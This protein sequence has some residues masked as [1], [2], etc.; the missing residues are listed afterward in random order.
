MKAILSFLLLVSCCLLLHNSNASFTP[1]TAIVDFIDYN[2]PPSFYTCISK[3]FNYNQDS[4]VIVTYNPQ[5]AIEETVISLRNSGYNFVH[6]LL[7]FNV[8]GRLIYSDELR[9]IATSLYT[10][11]TSVQGIW[12]AVTANPY[13]VPLAT[14]PMYNQFMINN[15]FYGVSS[16]FGGMGNVTMGIKTNHVD[17]NNIIGYDVDAFNQYPLWTDITENNS[18]VAMWESAVLKQILANSSACVYPANVD[19]VLTSFSIS[20]Q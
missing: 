1:N 10:V 16:Y 13:W 15:I 20:P 17:W 2:Y 11:G 3:R 4:I 18:T 12:I 9:S 19:M 5:V 7:D 8:A 6:I 14:D